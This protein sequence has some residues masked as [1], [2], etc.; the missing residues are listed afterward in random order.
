VSTLED[1]L[2]RFVSREQLSSAEA[3][4]CSVCQRRQPAVKQLSVRRLPPVL[5]LHVKRFEHHHHHR[6]HAS[7]PDAARPGGGLLE[8]ADGAGGDEDGVGPGGEARA[9]G[10]LRSSR[11]ASRKIQVRSRALVR[12]LW[13]AA[14]AAPLEPHPTV[15]WPCSLRRRRCPSR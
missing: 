6:R 14:A 2:R 11:H 1:C 8:G 5:T 4:V 3:W 12:A 7:E 9:A 13:Q 15:L 10:V